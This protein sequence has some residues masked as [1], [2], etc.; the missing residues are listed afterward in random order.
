MD[1]D[2]PDQDV[3]ENKWKYIEKYITKYKLLQ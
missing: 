1:K 2:H 3:K